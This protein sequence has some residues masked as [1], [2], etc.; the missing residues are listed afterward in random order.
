[1]IKSAKTV[2]PSLRSLRRY[3]W[4]GCL[5][6]LVMLG[7]S[8]IWA[9]VTEISGA[10]IA[11]GNVVVEGNSKKVQHLE[12]GIVA[13][14]GVRNGDLVESGQVLLR[15]DDTEIRAN[16]QIVRSQLDELLARRARLTAERDNADVMAP[17]APGSAEQTAVWQGQSKLFQSRRAARADKELQLGERIGQL[18]QAILGLDAQVTSKERQIAFLDDELTGVFQLQEQQLIAKPRVL[19]LQ[20]ERSKLDGERGQLISDIART[21]VQISETRFQLAEARQTFISDVLTELRDVETKVAELTEREVSVAAK[22]RRLAVV[23]PMSGMVHKLT[24]FTVGGVIGVGET[25]ME[26][27]PQG[28]RLVVEGQLDPNSVDQVRIGQQVR[29]R[30]AALDQ[31]VTPEIDGHL[32]SISPDVRQDAPQLPRYY[33]IRASILETEIGKLGGARLVPGMPTE[34]IIRRDE[35]TVLSYLVKPIVDQLAHVF[36]ER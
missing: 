12:G 18:Q 16:L 34:L 6:I 22:M 25:I 3:Q 32:L 24:V 14:A 21:G 7:G 15:L 26:I 4:L 10:V 9:S 19:I 11:P 5:A 2:S 8:S 33:A 27:V 28:E 35:R 36:R 23:A 17:R 1:M 31:R 13:L 29:M 20:R 30:F